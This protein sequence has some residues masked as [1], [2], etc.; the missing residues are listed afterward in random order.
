MT[1]EDFVQTLVGEELAQYE[2][3]TILK[4]I[5]IL[6]SENAELRERLERAVELPVSLETPVLKVWKNR[7]PEDDTRMSF[8]DMWEITVVNFKLEHYPLWSKFYFPNTKEGKEAAEARLAELKGGK[9][10]NF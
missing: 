4:S 6:K 2:A 5:E 9:Y 10:E 8:V 7:V 3:D 1:D